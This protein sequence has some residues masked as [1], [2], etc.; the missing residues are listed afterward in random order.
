MQ[1]T[2]P[3]INR[4]FRTISQADIQDPLDIDVVTTTGSLGC[5]NTENGQCGIKIDAYK[6]HDS[7]KY[8]SDVWK[9]NHTI[10]IY[11]RQ[12]GDFALI[13][14]HVTLRFK[15][16]ITGRKGVASE[17]FHDITLSD[18]QVNNCRS[19]IQR[20][21]I[22]LSICLKHVFCATHKTVCSI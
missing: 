12:D 6:K 22:I 20:G 10:T 11:N 16:N 18:V 2:I 3:F 7:Y 15:T 17:I 9:A 4:H 19:L 8:E 13:D 1:F 5:D 14:K 21:F